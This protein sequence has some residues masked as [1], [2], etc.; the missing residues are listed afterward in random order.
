MDIN[1]LKKIVRLLEQSSVD[2][3]VIEEEGTKIRV[4][5]NAPQMVPFSPG[6]A[7]MPVAQTSAAQPTVTNTEVPKAEAAKAGASY[8]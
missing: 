4:A 8:H 2:E 5:K 7:P 1:Y 6:S 3:I